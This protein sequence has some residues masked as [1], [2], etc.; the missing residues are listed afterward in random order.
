MIIERISLRVLVFSH[1]HCIARKTG[2]EEGRG[3]EM[4]EKEEKRRKG[5]KGEGREGEKGK[6]ERRNKTHTGAPELYLHVPSP[7]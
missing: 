1:W 2:G 7:C 4:R 3:G 6:R 5:R